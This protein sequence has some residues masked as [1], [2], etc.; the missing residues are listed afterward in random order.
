MWILTGEVVKNTQSL[1]GI[2]NGSLGSCA[3]RQCHWVTERFLSLPPGH[4]TVCHQQSLLR[5]PCM[6]SFRRAMK[7]HYSSHLSHHLSH[8]IWANVTCFWPCQVT[9][10][11]SD[12]RHHNLF[13]FTLHYTELIRMNQFTSTAYASITEGWLPCYTLIQTP[14]INFKTCEF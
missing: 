2:T 5:Q 10:Q 3:W 13:F 6:H 7:T 8:I 1:A 14:P 12:L 4:E 9:L 11:S